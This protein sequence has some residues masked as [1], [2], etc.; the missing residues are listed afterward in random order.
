[1]RGAHRNCYSRW[2]CILRVVFVV[3]RSFAPFTIPWSSGIVPTFRR[4]W[5]ATSTVRWRVLQMAEES[6]DGISDE[7]GGA[8]EGGGDDSDASGAEAEAVAAARKS[9]SKVKGT[10]PAALGFETSTLAAAAGADGQSV[11]ADSSTAAPAV[12]A[13]GAAALAVA[14]VLRADG[15]DAGDGESSSVGDCDGQSHTTGIVPSTGFPPRGSRSNVVRTPL[16]TGPR[17]E[18]PQRG[19]CTVAFKKK[20][21]WQ[22]RS[23]AEAPQG[24][25]G[26][27]VLSFL[28]SQGSSTLLIRWIAMACLKCATAKNC[29][30]L[31]VRR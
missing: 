10:A 5:H 12:V 8:V 21:E 22:S 2:S 24:S 28:F 9:T 11:T 13:A 19:T 6:Y 27:G 25:T 31:T 29:N 20:G 1:M 16:A 18:P 7:A 17:P 4:V 14:R 30:A 26:R 15:G 23:G 3:V